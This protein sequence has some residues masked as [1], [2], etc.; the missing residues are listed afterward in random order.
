MGSSTTDVQQQTNWSMCFL[1]QEIKPSE[2][3]VCPAN[4]RGST[5]GYE[6][7]ASNLQQFAELGEIPFNIR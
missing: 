6:T 5:S 7:I 1:C 2:K 3:L 4:G